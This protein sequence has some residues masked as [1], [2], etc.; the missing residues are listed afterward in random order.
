MLQVA[1]VAVENQQQCNAKMATGAPCGHS[2]RRPCKR[3]GTFCI[4]R[5]RTSYSVTSL[6]MYVFFRVIPRRLNFICLRFGILS[7]PSS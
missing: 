5:K 4:L 1:L 7:V 6:V 2:S 3:L